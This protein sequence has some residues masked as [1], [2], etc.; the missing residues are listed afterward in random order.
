M[1]FALLPHLARATT[2][3]LCRGLVTVALALGLAPAE[4]AA[5][6]GEFPKLFNS[7]VETVPL[8]KPTEA[9][10]RMHL[11]PGFQATLFA[12]EPDVQQP[13]G[14]TTDARGRLWVAEYNVC[15]TLTRIFLLLIII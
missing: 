6:G 1:N 8:L 14:M 9:V 13:I 10:R 4:A 7:Q 12:G 15:I 2:P 3:R 11:P 5:E